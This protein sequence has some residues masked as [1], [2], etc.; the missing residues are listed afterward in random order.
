MEWSK[1]SEDAKNLIKQMLSYNLE[2][3]ITAAEALNNQWIQK[4]AP[5]EPLNSTVLQN[6]S[7]F[8][9]NNNYFYRDNIK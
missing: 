9:V 6:L 2:Q 1:I 8:H 7:T 4:N 5:N 3:R